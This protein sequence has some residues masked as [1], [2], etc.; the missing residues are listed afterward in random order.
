MSPQTHLDKQKIVSKLAWLSFTILAVSFMMTSFFRAST[1][2]LAV[3]IMEDFQVGGGLMSVM[4]SAFF[5]PY[6]L[7]QLP[8]GIMADRWGT[9]KVTATF[10]VLGALGGVLFSTAPNVSIATTGRIILGLGM[11]MVFVPSLKVLL[12]WFPHQ[13]YVMSVGLYLSIGAIGMLFA[14]YPLAGMAR[15]VGWRGSM[16]AASILTLILATIVYFFIRDTPEELG[17]PAPDRK[18]EEKI[19][20]IPLKDVMIKLLHSRDYWMLCIWLFTIYGTFYSLTSLWAGPYFSQGYGLK[21][22]SV[23]CALLMLAAGGTISPSIAGTLTY[24]LKLSKKTILILSSCGAAL[25]ASP[26][27]FTFPVIP[28]LL[29]PVWCF[30]IGFFY[31]GFGCIA[32]TRIQEIFPSNVLGT[33]TG[34]A[35]VFSYAGST[36]LQLVSGWFIEYISCGQSP[37]SIQNYASMFSIFIV[38]AIIAI[39]CLSLCQKDNEEILNL[40]AEKKT[41]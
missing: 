35:N 20:R 41:F 17:L 13:R 16:L 24:R 29:I 14:S 19:E 30:F 4:S 23:G 15:L 22:G 12:A 7:M 26:L 6:G 28:E 10:L 21:E 3:E 33:A 9:R 38:A 18:K 32:M 27:L 2:T 11:G 37:Y 8:A 34:L 5:Y 25:T 36:I 39:L 1:S 31:G 40:A